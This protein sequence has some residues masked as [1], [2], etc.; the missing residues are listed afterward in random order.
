MTRMR[1]RFW[2]SLFRRQPVEQGAADPL[3]IEREMTAR[4]LR[5]A[6][7]DLHRALEALAGRLRSR[8]PRNGASPSH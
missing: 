2:D 1:P 7:T 6:S 3:T 5:A 4:Q 8:E